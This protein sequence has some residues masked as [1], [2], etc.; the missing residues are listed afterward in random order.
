MSWLP[1]KL[2]S[3]G[4]KRVGM[5][6]FDY[7][8]HDVRTVEKPR[9]CYA[10]IILPIYNEQACINDTF[11][12]V[13]QYAKDH[14]TYDFI[15]VN[16]GSTDR[17]ADVLE[18]RIA[19]SKSDR[20][21]LVSYLKRGGKGYAVR[22]GVEVADG[23]YICFV[24]GDLAYSLDHLDLMLSKLECYEV[25]IGC[26]GLALEGNQG[27]KL[28]RKVAGKIFNVLSQQI[29]NLKYVD[30][31]AGLKGF[32]KSAAKRLFSLQ[33]L[34]GFSF[35]VELMYLARKQGY[36]IAEIPAQVSRT[37]NH[38]QSKVNLVLDSLKMLKDLL[39]VRINDL[40]G[41]YE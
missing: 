31:Q 8:S 34:N 10:S 40:L 20:I 35:D 28:I 41:R 36:A 2:A 39:R 12:A 11:A 1:K 24:D 27:L 29:L 26:R 19:E 17:T 30:M 22:R 16:D 9:A 6:R 15:F 38:K 7:Y 25:V 3:F 37:H 33:E 21:L 32:Q 14:P 5:S 23:D 13:L 4:F 18:A